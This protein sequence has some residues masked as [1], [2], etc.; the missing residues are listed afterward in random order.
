MVKRD[1]LGAG[2]EFDLIRSFLRAQ[3]DTGTTD[4]VT[5]PGDD[6]AVIRV[7][8]VA[9]SVDMS[10]EGVH[11]RREWLEPEEI[12]YRAAAAAMSDLA[13]VAARPV[14]L[15]VA[16]AVPAGDEEAA[17]RIMAGAT[18]LAT[19]LSA[20]VLG[21]DVTR[22]PA[23]LVIDVVAVGAVE[24]PVLRS[25]ALPGHG[26]WVTG[27]L[28]GA[29]AAVRA[30]TDGAEPGGDAR[31]AFSRPRPRTAE[32]A[33][34]AEHAAI[35]AMIDLSDGLAGDLTHIAAASG[36]GIIVD[37]AAV[38]VHAA[39][40]TFG[41]EA[42]LR[43]A[44]GGGEDYELCLTADPAVLAPMEPAFRER[45]RVPLVRVGDV[46]AASGVVLRHPDGSQRAMPVAGFDHLGTG[47]S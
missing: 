1:A 32:A 17:R 41:A 6:C 31:A 27:A 33:W 43:L 12:G 47:G 39:A 42:G 3:P 22:S 20:V 7:G 26:V 28:G 9:L 44:L 40:S 11:F 29:A 15:L 38:P 19:S 21:G 16:L 24:T 8:G 5:G 2:A 25:G 13:A 36:V 45:F 10:I 4:V 46:V 23:A 34:L 18:S 30:W 35:G 37:A 14:G